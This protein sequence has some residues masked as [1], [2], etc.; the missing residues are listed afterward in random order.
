M[1]YLLYGSDTFRSRKKLHE[2]I[3]EYRKK[4][5][6]ALNL[7]RFDAEDDDIHTVKRMFETTSL[8]GGKRLMVIENAIVTGK[9]KNLNIQKFEDIVTVFWEGKLDGKQLVE[10]RPY[11]N[12]VQEFKNLNHEQTRRWIYEEAKQRGLKL[13]PAHF[14]RLE[15]LGSD[16][17][18]LSGE[19]DK[20]AISY[21][22]NESKDTKF[23]SLK[24]P[25]IFDLGDTFFTSRRE[26]LRLLL[27]LLN[28]G[29]DDF[30][31]FSYLANH[32]RTLLIVKVYT[33]LQQSVPAHHGLH[34]FVIKKAAQTVR[35]L[36]L[37]NLQ[38]VLKY[39]FEEDLKI[40]IG[41]SKPKEA[42]LRILLIASY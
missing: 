16:L 19:L 3:E 39:F 31:I 12:T 25:T 8:F 26:A 15:T 24:N 30:N 32:C 23:K 22:G 41:L 38:R 21:D 40:K 20:I 11:I 18:S 33:K 1:I 13:Y 10:T 34:P 14:I 17:W 4:A 28:Q 2:I 9:F 36:S 42:L 27:T 7:Y 29:Q 37:E 6:T 35:G 5:G